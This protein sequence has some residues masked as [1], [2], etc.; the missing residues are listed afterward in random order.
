MSSGWRSPR[1]RCQRRPVLR[2]DAGRR[3][4]VG[5]RPEHMQAPQASAADHPRLRG[6]VA[7]VEPLGPQKLVHVDIDAQPVLSD[8]VLEIAGDGDASVGRDIRGAEQTSA[9]WPPS[10]LESAVEVGSEID[11]AIP[12]EELHFFDPDTGMALSG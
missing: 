7:L 3:V 11:L 6:K 1:R 5:L 2:R 9:R 8:T 10:T 4:I 12:T